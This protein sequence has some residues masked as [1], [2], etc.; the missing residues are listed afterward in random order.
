VKWIEQ[1]LELALARKPEP[2]PEAI[3]TVPEVAAVAAAAS[4]EASVTTAVKH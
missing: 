1:V 4:T 2:L 3:P